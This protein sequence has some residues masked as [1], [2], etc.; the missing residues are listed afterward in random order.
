MNYYLSYTTDIVDNTDALSLTQ[1]SNHTC[2]NIRVNK[3]LTGQKG[4]HSKTLKIT[5]KH[6]SANSSTNA[7]STEIFLKR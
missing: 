7:E 4:R 2:R 1:L 5:R 3:I 6:S